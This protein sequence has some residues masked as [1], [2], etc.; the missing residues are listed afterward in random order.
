[1]FKFT[2]ILCL[3]ILTFALAA[4]YVPR[5][6]IY[7]IKSDINNIFGANINSVS[8]QGIQDIA[9]DFPFE[10]DSQKIIFGTD[11]T[12]AKYLGNA[13]SLREIKGQ[14]YLQGIYKLTVA[15]ESDF[16]KALQWLN[17]QPNIIAYAERNYIAKA[18]TIPNDHMYEHNQ[19]TYFQLM[20]IE[21]AWDITTNGVAVAILDTGID[22]NH[23]D[24]SDNYIGGYD[25]VNND[26]DPMDDHYRVDNSGIIYHSHGTHVAG[27][28]AAN[29]NNRIGVAGV[30]WRVPLMAVKVLGSDG[31]GY[32]EYIVKGIR[33]A[34]NNGARIINM[35]L[36][37]SGYS[38]LLQ[39]AIDYAY[40]NNVLIVA[41]A[42]NDDHDLNVYPEYP[43]CN[44]G[45]EDKV[46]GVASIGN[47]SKRSDE[48]SNYSSTYVDISAVGE[49][50]Q[51]TIRLNALPNDNNYA[52]FDGTSMAAPIVS[53]VAALLWS[54]RPSMT[55]SELRQ[56]IR[57]GATDI[58]S[59]NSGYENKLGD[60]ILNASNSMIAV[61]GI[62]TKSNQENVEII[63][64]YSYP[65]PVKYNSYGGITSI[66]FRLISSY[67][68]GD[69]EIKIYTVSGKLVRKISKTVLFT[70]WD[71]SC[72]LVDDNN[73]SMPPGIYIAVL[74]V[75]SNGA[76]K[77]HKIVIK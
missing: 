71:I 53:G 7:K 70:D 76:Q 2:K 72:A 68:P 73:Y 44:D 10:I 5:E 27:I 21:Q 50:V 18:T 67:A 16:E 42:G 41:A 33:Y 75:R 60:G 48:F 11:Q 6:I 26:N 1:M 64:F 36:S 23:P 9:P 22:N 28:V 65:N 54:Q 59:Y 39:G 8:P 35:S 55:V 74:K 49:N 15:N 45:G 40:A 51:S 61:N 37:G 19:R 12:N 4:D 43:V 56:V 30:A 31:S 25:F 63:Q 13:G 17:S 66:K 32:Y 38:Q 52:A 24:L 46:L 20:G 77:V 3:I 34:V 58:N 57:L 47:N 29:T 62:P 14:E 69:V